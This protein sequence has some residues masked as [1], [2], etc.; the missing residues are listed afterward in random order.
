MP[1]I[2]SLLDETQNLPNIPE[3]VRELIQSLNEREPDL[4]TIAKH[5]AKDP[6]IS[7]K[8]L[9]VANS[10]RFGGNRQ[11]ATV[12]E[13]VVR[14]GLAV[15]RNMVLA[16]G[17]TGAMRDIPGIDLRHY[18]GHV[19]EVAE[20]ARRLAVAAKRNGE[21][22]FTCALIHDL[23]RLVMHA[24]L[25][26]HTIHHIVD[27]EPTKGRAKAEALVVGF[28]YAQVGAEL[29]RQWHFP[30]FICQAVE[31]HYNPIKAPEFSADAAL[32]H[33]ALVLSAQ[34]G[35]SEA[36]PLE[37]PGEISARVGLVW[38]RC[39]AVLQEARE[40]D[41]PFAALLAA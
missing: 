20:L 41:N 22:A 3:V 14:L 27:L 6:V 7:A 38:E 16:S 36:P 31:F 30:D 28:N 17:L 15:V 4:L 40:Q 24:G 33:L 35:V 19:F 39:A 25:P 26:A 18:W 2:A 13:A 11:I 10:A 21:E 37:W 34:S 29:A 5:I 9:R 1:S 8:L 12:N 23:G 32:I